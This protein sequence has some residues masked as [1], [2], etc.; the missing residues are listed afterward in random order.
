MRGII[1]LGLGLM[2]VVLF[3]VAWVA[4]SYLTNYLDEKKKEQHNDST[5]SAH[6]TGAKEK[7]LP[8]LAR[9]NEGGPRG[10]PGASPESEQLVQEL[11]KLRERQESVTRQEQ[12]V[13]ARR[14]ALEIIQQDIR[15][16]REDID[17]V[18][19][20]LTEQVKGASDD[21]T[22]V[23][24]R[25]MQLDEK[26]RETEELV[27]DAKKGIYEADSVRSGG[28]KRLGGIL[29]TAEPAEV[30]SIFERMV[31]SGDLMTAAQILVNMKDRKAA[32]VL[33]QFQDKTVAAQLAE[34]MVGLK[35][36]AGV[37]PAGGLGARPRPASSPDGR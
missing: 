36:S 24:R 17:K 27:K 5:A 21:M 19:K 3:A 13:K 29:D 9:G 7:E 34:K 2:A 11:A 18:R 33:S 10:R 8:P 12:E 37:T 1:I 26:R 4:S 28:V 22:A 30:A 16:E 35:Q 15:G 14:R 6:D 23:E 31:E 25:A 20:D 32:A